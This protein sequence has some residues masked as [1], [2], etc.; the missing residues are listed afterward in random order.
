M[1]KYLL[2]FS[3]MLSKLL[4]FSCSDGDI[5]LVF[6]TTFAHKHYLLASGKNITMEQ[7]NVN[8]AMTH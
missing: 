8:K 2:I 6:S 7:K 5:G 1:P 3:P 4:E